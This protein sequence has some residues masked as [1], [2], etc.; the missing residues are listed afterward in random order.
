MT[1]FAQS[2]P[3]GLPIG[4]DWVVTR[5][6]PVLF[7][8]NGEQVALAPVGDASLAT[9]AIDSALAVRSELRA[10]FGT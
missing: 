3:R 1:L 10:T 2:W 5:E 9:S 4:R 7:P 8:F 6:E